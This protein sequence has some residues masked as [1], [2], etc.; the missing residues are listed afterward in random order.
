MQ[1]GSLVLS[2]SMFYKSRVLVNGAVRECASWSVG[3][4]L[5][6]DLPA[7]VA[8]VSGLVQATGT[9]VWVEENDVDDMPT[10]PFNTSSGWLPRRGNRVE[11]FAGDGTTEWKVFTG[12]VDS[13][14]GS[15][16]ESLQSTII[17]DRDKLSGDFRHDA[18]L[19][20]MPPISRGAADYRGVGLT[21]LYFVDAALRTSGFYAT[22]PAEARQAVSVPAQSS[23]WPERGGMSAGA[24]GGYEPSAP[25]WAE[26]YN[27]VDGVAI[28]NVKCTYAPSVSLPFG[29][30]FRM[31]LT[32]D[33]SHSGSS[34]VTSY[35][36]GSNNVQLAVAPSRTVVARCNGV[37]VC[38]L[39][40][41]SSVRVSLVIEG[42]SWELRT[43]TG[44]SSSGSIAP[45][46]SASLDR[47]VVLAD[48][49]A[50]V[51]GFHVC[52]PATST[53]WDYTKFVPSAKYQI[54]DMTLFGIIDAAPAIVDGSCFDLLDEIS[55]A[56]L[57]AMWIDEHGV[58]R[59]A[60]STT[61]AK[62][63]TV[64]ELNTADDILSLPWEDN[65][66]G[67]R[68]KV[69]VKQRVPAITVS[70]WDN[71]LWH[72]GSAE[73]M[74]SGQ[75]KNDFISPEADEDWV[76]A[77]YPMILLGD[78]GG[79]SASN[80]GHGSFS[81]A[82]L[83]DGTVEDLGNAYLTASLSKVNAI[84]YKLNH[85]V[86]SLPSGKKLELRY[87]SES[88]TIWKRWLKQSFPV[89]RGHAK[90]SWTDLEVAGSP[91]GPSWAPVLDHEVGHWLSR[92]GGED[93]VAIERLANYLA[94]QTSASLPTI[95]DMPVV[96]DPRLQLGDR[97]TIRSDKYIGAVFT[98]IITGISLSAGDSFSQS[99]SVRLTSLQST[100]QSYDAWNSQY[101][102][103]LTYDQWAVLTTQT[104]DQFAISKD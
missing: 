23:M 71:V 99:I 21:Y 70:R 81:G 15:V 50:R 53:R 2:D 10:T 1:A 103:V 88:S 4:E 56:T 68:S 76:G 85:S 64:R 87:P 5:S 33:P 98:A 37:E 39:A 49:G 79:S 57:S 25:S 63:A 45:P 46:T 3:R 60:P 86:G 42:S 43:N 17:D 96:P 97:V 9:I 74:E 84:T 58:F 90:T 47:V 93:G 12:L 35:F 61:L 80:S 52:Y 20:V 95:G 54:D 75:V 83:T 59:W 41:G 65:L 82:V 7:Q 44:V 104:Y 72:Q 14:S 36:D 22:P 48:Q 62:S 51:A 28:A 77:T 89:I 16:G 18:L 78:P 67:T 101:P 8:A 19:R 38:R 30:L 26:T 32:I 40:M 34:Y 69:T 94:A 91:A 66:L 92:E 6:G 73:T 24:V 102:G 13:S 11:I 29:N 27:S 55:Q 31:S 100:F